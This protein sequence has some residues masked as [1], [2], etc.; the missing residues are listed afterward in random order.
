MVPQQFLY[1]VAS[2]S[3]IKDDFFHQWKLVTSCITG[4]ACFL[5]CLFVIVEFSVTLPFT[6]LLPMYLL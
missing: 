3:L 4:I 5:F 2:S 1:R 6:V